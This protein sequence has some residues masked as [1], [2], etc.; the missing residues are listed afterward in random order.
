MLGFVRL[1]GNSKYILS[2]GQGAHEKSK[3]SCAGKCEGAKLSFLSAALPA[4][5]VERGLM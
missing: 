4:H 5:D 3:L 2:R 1:V